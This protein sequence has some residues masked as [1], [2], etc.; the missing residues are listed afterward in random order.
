MQ[1]GKPCAYGLVPTTALCFLDWGIYQ[2]DDCHRSNIAVV[3][4][5][6][7]PGVTTLSPDKPGG[8]FIEQLLYDRI[9]SYHLESLAACMEIPTL[10]QGHQ[11]ISDSPQFFSFWFSRDDSFM[12][13]QGG[14]EVPQ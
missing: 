7:N 14:C 3:S 10:A 8:D 12:F 5:T 4:K 6:Q 13:K 2:L 1:K 9:A 11:L